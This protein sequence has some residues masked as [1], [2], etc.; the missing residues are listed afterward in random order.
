ML[1][2]KAK[3]MYLV[4]DH[5]T[6]ARGDARGGT[7]GLGGSQER[8][9]QQVGTWCGAGTSVIGNLG[10][11]ALSAASRLIALANGSGA[12]LLRGLISAFPIFLSGK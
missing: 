12:E 10:R 2:D 3:A 11:A 6:S 8:S 5:R 7:G 1:S 9:A 4:L